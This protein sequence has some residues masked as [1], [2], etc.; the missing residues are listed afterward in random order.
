MSLIDKANKFHWLHA[1]LLESYNDDNISSTPLYKMLEKYPAGSMLKDAEG[2]FWV[3][4][5]RAAIIRYRFITKKIII[6]K[7]I[8]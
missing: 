5:A 4:R 7:N 1:Q 2:N 3:R 8:W 6:C